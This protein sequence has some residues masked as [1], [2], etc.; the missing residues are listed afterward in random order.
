M[1][2]TRTLSALLLTV[3]LLVLGAVL[4][5]I[6]GAIQ[7]CAGKE[8]G[9]GEIQS[10]DLKLKENLSLTNKLYVM[11]NGQ[12][13]PISEDTE[14]TLEQL[15]AVVEEALAPYY[16]RELVPYNWKDVSFNAE[17]YIL[18]QTNEPEINFAIWIVTLEMDEW[19]TMLH[20]D[21]ETGKILDIQHTALNAQ[22]IYTPKAYTEQFFEAWFEG[23]GLSD[24]PWKESTWDGQEGNTS[25]IRCSYADENLNFTIEFTAHPWGFW[26]AIG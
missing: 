11:G 15:P 13:Y 9:F 14:L 5:G 16:Y 22:S 18:Y 8:P 6:V 1:K 7:N 4:P 19:R 2:R 17:P 23:L 10:V 12:Y 24:V 26:L 21:D 20:L 25:I 3:C